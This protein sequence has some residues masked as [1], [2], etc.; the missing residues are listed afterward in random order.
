MTRR[1]KSNPFALKFALQGTFIFPLCEMKD[2]AA[3]IFCSI[4]RTATLF[5]SKQKQERGR[6]KAS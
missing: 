2:R 1:K 3:F 6:K 4:D 5:L